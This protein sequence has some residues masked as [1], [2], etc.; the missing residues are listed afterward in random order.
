MDYISI[1]DLEVFAKH[2]VFPEEQRLGQKFLVS[3]KLY[4]DLSPAGKSDALECSVDYGKVCHLITELMTENTYKLLEKAA[5]E[6]AHMLLVTFAG[7]DQAEVTVKKPWAPIGL[8]LDTAAV[9]VTRKW[10][11]TYIAL[12]SNMGDCE[13]YLNQA[14]LQMEE[15]ENCRVTAVSDYII[16]KPYGGVAQDDFLN[17]AAIVDTLYTPEELLGFLHEIEQKAD[18]KRDVHWGPRTLDLDILFYGNEV[19]QTEELTIPHPDMHN[20]DFVLQPLDQLAPG[21]VHPLLQK[22]VRNML[23]QLKE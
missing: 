2:G 6:V 3:A 20:R 15:N 9:T 22:T 21:F 11:R 18:R 5:E 23:L 10:N 12:G 13:N 7:V 17:G 8:P 14:V 19:V 16:T 4:M 1:Q